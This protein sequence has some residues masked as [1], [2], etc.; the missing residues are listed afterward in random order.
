MCIGS[1]RVRLN[2]F[3]ALQT[4]SPV[5]RGVKQNTRKSTSNQALALWQHTLFAILLTIVRSI[6][7]GK[8]DIKLKLIQD[9]KVALMGVG[10]TRFKIVR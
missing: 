4:F 9:F 8:A 5:Q 3:T 1:Q 7:Q 6:L 2:I 10:C